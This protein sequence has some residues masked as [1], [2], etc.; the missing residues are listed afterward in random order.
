[1]KSKQKK[2][3]LRRFSRA[4]LPGD[5][6]IKFYIQMAFIMG[7]TWIT[8]FVMTTF[9]LTNQVVY[10]IFVYVFILSNCLCGVFIF[11]SFVFKKETKKFV[12]PL[13]A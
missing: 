11:F 9:S 8:G 6:D 13:I 10:Q 5:Q 4:K 12:E 1:M 2:S 3:E 7:F